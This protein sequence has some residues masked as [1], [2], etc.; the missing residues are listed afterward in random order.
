MCVPFPIE[1]SHNLKLCA[2]EEVPAACSAALRGKV[3]PRQAGAASGGFYR[4][5]AGVKPAKP[6][7]RSSN[8]SLRVDVALTAPR[9]RTWDIE[10][11]EE[12]GGGLLKLSEHGYGRKDC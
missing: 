7:S 1:V 3:L 4:L 5:T 12:I 8:S 2:W 10:L 6:G 11:P 9:C